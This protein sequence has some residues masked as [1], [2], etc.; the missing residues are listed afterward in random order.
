MRVVCEHCGLPFAV[1]RVTPGRAVY[2]CSGCALAARMTREGAGSRG[3]DA[4]LIAAV[5]GAF[6]FFNQMLCWLLAELIGERGSGALTGERLLWASLALGSGVW[7]AIL[8]GQIRGATLRGLDW[9]VIVSSAG[10]WGLA[11]SST[12]GPSGV[13]A[14]ALLGVWALRGLGRKKGVGTK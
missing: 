4:A 8:A 5:G 6:V 14:N 3:G 13:V 9:G 7:L 12:S 2:C 11:W 10:L 1:A